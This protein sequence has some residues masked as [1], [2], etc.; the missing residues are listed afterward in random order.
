MSSGLSR[1]RWPPPSPREAA[2]SNPSA[3]RVKFPTGYADSAERNVLG[4]LFPMRVPGGGPR[5]RGGKRVRRA[6]P[7]P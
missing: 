3:D 7:C 6:L 2:M 1:E 4:G 5:R